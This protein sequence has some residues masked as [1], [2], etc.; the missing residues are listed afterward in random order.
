MKPPT[1]FR[2]LFLAAAALSVAALPVA[3]QPADDVPENTY[4][5][6]YARPST[7][8]AR[9]SMDYAA[10]QA[11][12]PAGRVGYAHVTAAEGTGSVLSDAK[13]RTEMQINL[14]LSEGDQLVTRAAGRAEVE[15]ADGNRVQIAGESGVRFDALAGEQGSGAEESALTLLEGSIAVE[16]GTFAGNRA[17]RVDTPD[18]S[19]YV[20]SG[21]QAR[22]NL[23]PHRGTTVIARRGTFDVQTRSGSIP[24][25]AGQYVIVQGDDQPEVARGTFSRDRFDVWVAQRSQTMLQAHNS[26]SARYLNDEAYDEDVAV[27]DHY[28]SWDYSPT[29]ETNVWR[30]DVSSDWSP[31][32]DGYWDY[33]P[34][35]ATWVD[36]E[37]WGWF[38]HHYGNWFFDAGFGSWCWSPASIY[39]PGW[40]YWGFSGGYTGWCPIGYYSYY[41]PWGSYWGWGWGSG[42]YFSVNGVFDRGRIDCGRGWNFVGTDSFGT[43]FGNRAV[44]SGTQV[45]SRLGSQIAVTSNPLRAP[46]VSGRGSASSAMRSLALS[47]PATI[48]RSSSTTQS[49]TLAPYLARQRTLPPQTV[50]ALRQAQVARVNPASRTLQGPGTASL[51]AV[52]ARAGAQTRSLQTRS[53][54]SRSLG[55]GSFANPG[56]GRSEAW[57]APGRTLSPGSIPTSPRA[58][59]QSDARGTEWRSRQIAPRGDTALPSFRQRSSDGSRSTAPGSSPTVP[60]RS[61]R[62]SEAPPADSWRARPVV[63]PAQRVIEGIDRGRA[64]PP[65]RSSESWRSIPDRRSFESAPPARVAPESR[66][67][68][69]QAPPPRYE[70]RPA[71][72]TFDRRSA[73]APDYQR[74]APP[75]P[76]YERQAPPPPPRAE[77]RSAPPR[78][79]RAAPPAREFR[80]PAPAPRSAP[81]PRQEFSRHNDRSPR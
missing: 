40:V 13:G 69:R 39:S 68:Q 46:L 28:G 29:Y 53:L 65:S 14:P 36:N 45:A 78:E 4:D 47:A 30:P 8:D 2:N 21:A 57:R 55:G 62:F 42:L 51:P 18:A 79:M 15:L 22:I 44:Q 12:R 72:P 54:P 24:V 32:S 50:N 56:S 19:V 64:L 74:Q 6:P 81:A 38:P 60:P 49:A 80:A 27:M 17:F 34:A 7:D 26:A 11:S 73:P 1:I 35:G 67:F 61:G 52:G 31:Y 16:T 59:P 71:L 63:P 58:L 76:R 10:P 23:D 9:P 66:Q 37:P 25:E 3:A 5:A 41:A 77:S 48:A 33:T 70:S 20:T 43:H 75:T